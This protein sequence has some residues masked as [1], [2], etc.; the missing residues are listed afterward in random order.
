MKVPWSMPLID[1]EE[2]NEVI[3]VMRSGWLSQGPKVKEL[4]L[5]FKERVG[6]RYAIAVS[7]GTAALHLALLACGLKKSTIVTT[8]LTFIATVEPI[9]HIGSVPMF[10]DIDEK[11]Y[12][13]LADKAID[14]IKDGAKAVLPV[15]LY[16]N[17]MPLEQIIEVASERN[18]PIIEDCAQA[19][20]AEYGGKKVPLGDI[21][22]FSFYPSKNLGAYGDGGCVVTNRKEVAEA[23][24]ALRDH[25]REPGEKYLH[26]QVG[27]N[28]RM[29]EL[30]AAIL[31]V[32]L[33][34]L[35]AWIEKRRKIAKL[36]NELLEKLENVITPQEVEG[37]KHVFHLYVIRITKGE[38]DKVRTYLASQGISTGIHYPIPLH[39]QP[40]LAFLGLSE[41]SYPKAEK[42]CR[43]VLSLPMYPELTD[44]QIH[45]VCEK[46]KEALEMV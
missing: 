23:V 35:D 7:S 46:L 6:S 12:H 33:K 39:L 22:C 29:D 32:K 4:E 17:P 42:I 5:L 30:Q 25:G 13:L 44:E 18:V 43:E 21:G 38:R 26:R 41:R 15:H 9:I 37:G 45:Y 2:L 16:G 1:E 8:P 14:S 10:T 36:Y 40:S 19:H 11:T 27:F 28:Y 24:K 34:H 20:G 31:N 3:K